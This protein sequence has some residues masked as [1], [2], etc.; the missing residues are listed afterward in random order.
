MRVN[1][2][3]DARI[4]YCIQFWSSRKLIARSWTSG[5][6]HERDD[7]EHNMRRKQLLLQRL[8]LLPHLVQLLVFLVDRQNSVAM[9]FEFLR[10]LAHSQPVF[11]MSSTAATVRNEAI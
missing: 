1:L 8:H 11:F 3:N 9:S 2:L 6:R 10:E 5:N 4:Y 7:D